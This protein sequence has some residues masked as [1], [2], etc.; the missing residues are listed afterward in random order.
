MTSKSSIQEDLQYVAGAVRR[1]NRQAGVPAIFFM[2]AAIILVGWSLPDFAPQYAGWFWVIVGPVG[3][4]VSWWLGARDA[5]Q[6]GD[7]DREHGKRHGL[8]WLLSGIAFFAVFLPFMTAAGAEG[9]TNIIVGRQFLL[10]VALVYALA[11][12]HLERGLAWPAAIMATGYIALT[13]WSPP[14]LWSTM[15]AVVA[16]SL[17]L[18][19][20]QAR[21]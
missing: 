4:L 18:A 11:A 1:R 12:V 16:V 7:L 3:G 10:M 19:G 6:S 14:Y 17:I 5:R 8:H 21:R 9:Y 13:V 20:L 15:G 2:W